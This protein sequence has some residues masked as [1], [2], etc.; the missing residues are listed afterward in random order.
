MPVAHGHGDFDLA[1]IGKCPPQR[2]CLR[3]GLFEQR[4]APADRA[5]DFAGLG[6]AAPGDQ[7]REQ[8]AQRPRRADDRRVAKQIAQKGFDGIERIPAPPRF[9][10]T[11]AV[12]L[13]GRSRR[14]TRATRSQS[15]ATVL[16]RGLGQ[17]AFAQVEHEWPMTERLQNASDSLP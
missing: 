7:A 4:R 6:A 10:R 5:V 13:I 14:A 8:P 3:L 9:M 15:S 1:Q 2:R 11:T 17:H 16:R 12:R